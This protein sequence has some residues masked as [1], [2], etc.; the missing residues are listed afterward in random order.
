MDMI[1]GAVKQVLKEVESYDSI[2]KLKDNV[3]KGI[4]DRDER[5]KEKEKQKELKAK[6]KKLQE[7]ITETERMIEF[8]INS[9]SDS[10]GGNKELSERDKKKKRKEQFRKL[11]SEMKKELLKTINPLHDDGGAMYNS[12]EEYFDRLIE[13][14]KNKPKEVNMGSQSLPRAFKTNNTILE[15]LEKIKA[16][17]VENN[18]LESFF[19]VEEM[20]CYLE[21][22]YHESHTI[23]KKYVLRLLN[24]EKEKKNKS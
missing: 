17:A 20:R 6:K 15:L 10:D 11:Y 1:R 24:L 16:E 12:T 18:E 8:K 7:D 19:L 22:A 21:E 4:R 23:N 2:Q 13:Q 14:N 3:I 5:D 9:F